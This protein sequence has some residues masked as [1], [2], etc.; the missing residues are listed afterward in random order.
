MKKL[1]LVLILVLTLISCEEEKEFKIFSLDEDK[2]V[3]ATDLASGYSYRYVTEYGLEGESTG[4][5]EVVIHTDENYEPKDITFNPIAA[6]IL[7]Q[8]MNPKNASSIY[9]VLTVQMDPEV[10]FSVVSEKELYDYFENSTFYDVI[11]ME[12]VEN[13][14]YSIELKARE[15]KNVII[16]YT[17]EM[18]DDH[19]GIL[20][21]N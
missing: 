3:E 6:N 13:D 11:Q 12:E 15:N 14:Q 20:T 19:K 18:D 8:T 1:L 16:S 9:G 5:M 2:I 17:F 7:H 10:T 21:L 4:I